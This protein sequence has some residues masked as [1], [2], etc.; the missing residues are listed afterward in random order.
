MNLLLITCDQYRA[1]ALSC[2]GH[3]VL[4][5]PA[6]DQL[7]ADGV[8]F[9]SHFGQA[10]PCSPG[11]ASLYT[12]LYMMNHRVV[13]NS[14]PLEDRHTNFAVE[15]RKLG[16]D[17][18]MAGYT[19]ICADPENMDPNDPTMKTYGSMR[20]ITS[21]EPGNHP[22]GTP[23]ASGWAS[24]L[25]EKG[26]DVPDQMFNSN[27]DDIYTDGGYPPSTV[28]GMVLPGN[29]HKIKEGQT[30]VDDEG[31]AAPAFWAAEHSESAYSA[32]VA[33]RH[34][35]ARHGAPWALHV[36]TFHPHPPWLAAAPFN[37]QYH[38]SQCGGT[39]RKPS[40]AEE[41]AAHPWLAHTLGS[42]GGLAPESDEELNILRSQYDLPTM[43]I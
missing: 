17:P 29:Y 25:E 8:R 38:H 24:W 22:R 34:I 21:L 40:R 6:L 32:A 41:G 16:Y 35:R 39:P 20:G 1:D 7:A 2:A 43:S 9:A 37:R 27:P 10:A 31:F 42:A 5:T 3:S 23:G 30:L 15:L 4:R 26:Y 11:R 19:D 14:S 36:S 18:V 12:G 33:M 28:D 13:S